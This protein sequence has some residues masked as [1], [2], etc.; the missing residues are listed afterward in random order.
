MLT[1]NMRGEEL[2]GMMRRRCGRRAG[3]T[4]VVQWNACSRYK[5]SKRE[6]AGRDL[7]GSWWCNQEPANSTYP[8]LMRNPLVDVST[9]MYS[10][11]HL[12]ELH[13]IGDRQSLFCLDD[14]KLTRFISR[15]RAPNR[16]LH[17]YIRPGHQAPGT[18]AND[19]IIECPSRSAR[20][21]RLPGSR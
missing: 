14:A 12:D 13:S 11:D 17:K 1:S 18:S 8:G 15:W 21:R 6:V 20:A 5:P 10:D 4:E 3:A 2:V 7:S 19:T 16:Y 9:G